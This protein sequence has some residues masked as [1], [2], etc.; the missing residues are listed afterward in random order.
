MRR[1][2]IA[3]TIMLC[4]PA[5]A[6]AQGKVFE[7]PVDRAKCGPGSRPEPA[8]ALQGEVTKDDRESGRSLE[9]YTCNMEF[10]GNQPG[11]G[12]ASWQHTWRDHC[13][14]YDT[15]FK[16]GYG[17]QVVDVSDPAKP[18]HVRALQTPAM[19]DPWESLSVSQ[20]RGLLAG[21]AVTNLFGAA[22]FD[23]YDVKEDCTNP[24]LITSVPVSG[25]N[26]EGDWA[27]DGMTYWATGT[28]SPTISAID[29]TNP[30]TPLPLGTFNFQSHGVS[31]S[32]DGNRLYLSASSGP[33]G[34]GLTILDG[35]K[36]QAREPAAQPTLISTLAWE[37]G[38]NAQHSIPVT[39][40]GKPFL[41]F[42]DESTQ[43]T[44]RFIDLTDEKKPR[45]VSKMKLEIHMPDNSDRAGETATAIFGY[46]AHYCNVDR[47]VDPTIVVCSMF[48]SGMRVFDVR[49]PYHP[50][51]IA[52]F[53]PGGTG[54][55]APA[56]SN[57]DYLNPGLIPTSGYPA[58]RPRIIP[59][60]AEIWWT[61]HNKGFFVT[62]FT[63]G[64]WPFKEGGETQAP[65]GLPAPKRC[66]DR[67]SISFK[68]PR[69]KAARTAT[70]YLNGKKV[71][72][73]RGKALRKRVR[74]KLPAGR[75]SAVRVVVLTRQ[76]KRVTQTRTYTRCGG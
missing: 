23:V 52:Y 46:N 65:V 42:V 25:F 34:N 26:H 61:D 39:F 36:I 64:V 30:Q 20:P 71:K 38:S 27:Y 63:N 24:A 15:A 13:A 14:Y 73:V 5:T 75:L 10:V 3:L 6:G 60:R 49:D 51:E 56:G 18:K 69:D 1:I 66:I 50:K 43:G 21:V 48:E 58:A 76:G 53:N 11:P 37:D 19:L 31:T 28:L 22:Q 8:K 32:W 12:G 72:T 54:K 55:A 33:E 68:V 40:K 2:L 29:V 57:Y 59:E 41:L 45:I 62:R 7:G 35:S 47:V 4:A 70:V 16:S 9:G 67:P 74:V 44:A 17:V